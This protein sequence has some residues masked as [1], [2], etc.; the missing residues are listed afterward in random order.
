[1]Q[2][3][4]PIRSATAGRALTRRPFVDRIGNRRVT[5][6]FV[7]PATSSAKKGYASRMEG[8]ACVCARIRHPCRMG[9]YAP[10]WE[11]A[12]ERAPAGQNSPRKTGNQ[13]KFPTMRLLCAPCVCGPRVFATPN[14]WPKYEWPFLDAR[15]S[16][17]QGRPFLRTSL[18]VSRGQGCQQ[19]ENCAYPA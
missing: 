6:D 2:F 8:Y 15:R 12:L 1:M 16:I 3:L 9:A 14:E 7:S 11:E 4:A 13:H 5:D 18:A 19:R 17:L 10:V